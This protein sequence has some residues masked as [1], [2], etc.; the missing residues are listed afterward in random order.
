MTET[1][2]S[3]VFYR[4]PSQLDGAP[5]IGVITGL[6]TASK[7]PKTGDMLQTYIL[8]EDISPPEAART[9]ADRSICGDCPLRGDGNNIGR[10]CYVQ[11]KWAPLGVW[12]SVR[13]DLATWYGNTTNE[14]TITR[15]AQQ[16]H[17]R[18]GTYGDPAAIPL[19]VWEWLLSGVAG[20][21]GYTHQWRACDGRYAT[22]CMASVD[23]IEEQA[24][25][26]QRGYRTF[27]V[28]QSTAEALRRDE[29]TCPASAE[30]GKRVTCQ[31]CRLCRGTAR[32]AKNIVIVAHGNRAAKA[33]MLTLPFDQEWPS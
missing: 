10:A 26:A 30:A 4:G 15:A 1:I 21:T 14:Y 3:R 33:G 7:N 17:I 16:R 13:P 32:V 25:A 2:N 6:A 28:R 27:R 9:G 18:L 24:E 5:I 12:K 8:R 31:Q 29:V 19:Y 11:T 22:I 23:S 20:W